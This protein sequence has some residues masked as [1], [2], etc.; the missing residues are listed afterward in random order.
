MD[1]PGS[2]SLTAEQQQWYLDRFG[3]RYVGVQEQPFVVVDDKAAPRASRA[4]RRRNRF[5][6]RMVPRGQF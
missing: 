3:E 1:G 5:R 6:P 4:E 2:S